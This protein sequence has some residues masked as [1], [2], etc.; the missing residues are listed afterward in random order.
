MD[1]NVTLDGF[2]KEVPQLLNFL[3]IWFIFCYLILRN[4]SVLKIPIKLSNF[5]SAVF[6]IMYYFVFC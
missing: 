5:Q 2:N 4:G 3:T 6:M 1:H